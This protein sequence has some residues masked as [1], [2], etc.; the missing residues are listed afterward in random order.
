AETELRDQLGGSGAGS[1]SEAAAERLS[2]RAAA[3][4]QPGPRA[5][6][7][8]IIEHDDHAMVESSRGGS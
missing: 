1:R 8:T 5:D 6:E 3:E 7:Q 2:G 4:L